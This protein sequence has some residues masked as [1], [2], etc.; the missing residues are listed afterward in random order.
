V[1]VRNVTV[2][3]KESVSHSPGKSHKNRAGFEL[4]VLNV[5]CIYNGSCFVR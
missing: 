2:K 4:N 5:A 3:D 1:S